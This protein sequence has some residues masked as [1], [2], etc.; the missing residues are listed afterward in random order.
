MMKKLTIVQRAHNNLD[1]KMT[2]DDHPSFQKCLLQ[3]NKCS[4]LSQ[5]SKLVLSPFKVYLQDANSGETNVPS[6]NYFDDLTPELE[7][8]I[9]AKSCVT[10]CSHLLSQ[11][12][13]I[14]FSLNDTKRYWK[15]VKGDW[16]STFVQ[17][18]PLYWM[19]KLING[20]YQG[21]D[22]DLKLTIKRLE[23]LERVN[24]T[25][26][27]FLVRSLIAFSQLELLDEQLMPLVE[28]F[29][30]DVHPLFDV[31]SHLT[32]ESPTLDGQPTNDNKT[33]PTDDIEPSE[34]QEERRNTYELVVAL[35]SCII[36]ACNQ[37]LNTADQVLKKHS[38]PGHFRRNWVKYVGASVVAGVLGRTAYNNRDAI[39][40][41]L[42]DVREATIRFGEQYVVNPLSNIYSVIRYDKHSILLTDPQ[43]LES[44]ITSL[45]NMMTQ[46]ASDHSL[47]SLSVEEVKNL[48]RMGDLSIIMRNYEAQIK[49]PI[50]NVLFGDVARIMLVQL[51]KQRVDLERA[52]VA[53]DKLLRSNEINFEMIA[54]MP[55]VLLVVFGVLYFSTVRRDR[56]RSI[57][58]QM[59]TLLSNV[60]KI[61]NGNNMKDKVDLDDESFGLVYLYTY[62]I[63]MLVRNKF[64]LITEMDDTDRYEFYDDL[65]EISHDNFEIS[66][67]LGT[68][69]RMFRCYS[70]LKLQ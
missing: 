40:N 58:Q 5:L 22:K 45:E 13:S 12:I 31:A 44:S 66:Q 20:S 4:S 61:L 56:D 8:L 37:H 57:Q 9:L 54:L 29:I 48:A 39:I 16:W 49:H 35:D 2:D 21:L 64:G 43:G 34:I 41:T 33:L 10:F 59:I 14:G 28:H 38:I 69:Q 26:V 15:S 55:A 53:M 70:F 65:R 67:K 42:F 30:K 25:I 18:G 47:K 46:Y 62:R 27:G 6:D 19:R 52:L 7:Q 36:R 32:S 24:A 11:C 63:K 1:S 68:V 51:Q 60:E 3:L 50:Y 23:E 17:K